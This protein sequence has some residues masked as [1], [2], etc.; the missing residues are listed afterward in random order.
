MRRVI[1]GLA[2][3]SLFYTGAAQAQGTVVFGLNQ[4][5]QAISLPGTI[6]MQTGQAIRVQPDVLNYY[7][8]RMYMPANQFVWRMTRSSGYWEQWDAR[9]SFGY[10]PF[11][12]GSETNSVYISAKTEMGNFGRIDVVAPGNPANAFTIVNVSGFGGAPQQCQWADPGIY[13][14]NGGYP[15]YPNPTPTPTAAPP[16][17]PGPCNNVCTEGAKCTDGC[18]MGASWCNFVSGPVRYWEVVACSRHPR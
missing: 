10:G 8:Q 13:I 3:A 17:S 5:G 2:L 14:N 1:F 12:M 4:F 7:G 11:Q 18:P 16:F 15:P 6:C 9:F